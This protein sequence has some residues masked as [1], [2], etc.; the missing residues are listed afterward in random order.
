MKI[1]GICPHVLGL[2]SSRVRRFFH[3]NAIVSFAVT[4]TMNSVLTFVSMDHPAR[5]F[6]IQML[7]TSTPLQ[8]Q[9]NLVLTFL[10][11]ALLITSYMLYRPSPTVAL[12]MHFLLLRRKKQL[13]KQYMIS[14]SQV[15]I[16]FR[17]TRIMDWLYKSMFLIYLGTLILYFWHLQY[18]Y[19]RLHP[20]L[21]WTISVPI[22]VYTIASHFIGAYLCFM[23]YMLF[24]HC[25]CFLIVRLTSL[26]HHFD[27]LAQSPSIGD[28]LY[29]HLLQIDQILCS[30]FT[31]NR[32]FNR[33]V[34]PFF[35]SFF[36]FSL[37]F[38][39]VAVFEQN[40][41]WFKVVAVIT[42]AM[43]TSTLMYSLCFAGTVFK[44]KVSGHR[45]C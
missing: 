44:K 45:R 15:D 12:R 17:F 3:V 5:L 24:L 36:V 13:I 28:E 43:T 31:F 18:A 23:S 16:Y 8:K 14:A 11:G 27:L 2:S 40:P 19:E 33:T 42:Y 20:S 35:F 4:T 34:C 7:A 38:P 41:V 26:R 10:A 25:A 32:F 30:T 39:Y 37:F 21:F 6:F 1:C 22:G 9:L 29:A